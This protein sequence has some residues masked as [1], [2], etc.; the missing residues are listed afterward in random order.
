MPL[1]VFTTIEPEPPEDMRLHLVSRGSNSVS[2][3]LVDRHGVT[4]PSGF[5]ATF[6]LN[7]VGKLM[8]E[9]CTNVN[10]DLVQQEV[11]TTKIKQIIL[12]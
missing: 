3:V 2:V 12:F 4:L 6:R 11:G 5:V 9:L 8:I 7:T 10:S 1:K